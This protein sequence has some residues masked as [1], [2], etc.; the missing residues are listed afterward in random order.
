MFFGPVLT[1]ATT[2]MI[3]PATLLALRGQ[4]GLPLWLGVLGGVAFAEQAVETITIFGSTGFTQP[5]GAMDFQLGAA[6]TLGWMLAFGLWGG[7]RGRFPS[8][9]A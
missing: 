6:L 1:G 5:G 2:T 8:P 3:A 4:A 7:L 9:V